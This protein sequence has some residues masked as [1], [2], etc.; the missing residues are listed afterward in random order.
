M[1]AGA[2]ARRADGAVL[3]F[4]GILLSLGLALVIDPE[5]GKVDCPRGADRRHQSSVIIASR[6]I[7]RCIEEAVL[8]LRRQDENPNQLE[9]VLLYGAGTRAQLFLKDRALKISKKMDKRHLVGF[10][11]DEKALHFQWF[12]G[13]WCWADSRNCRI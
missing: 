2:S 5:T 3:A 12:M 10:I 7:Y 6:L 8:W 13:C 4:C 1:A 9:R 11:D